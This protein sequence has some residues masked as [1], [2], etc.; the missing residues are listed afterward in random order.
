MPRSI[1]KLVCANL[2]KTFMYIL[3]RDVAF[4]D[5]PSDRSRRSNQLQDFPVQRHIYIVIVISLR[6][7]QHFHMLTFIKTE[8][9]E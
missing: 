4:C 6:S 3:I 1:R 8:L 2:K 9:L 7:F 5:F